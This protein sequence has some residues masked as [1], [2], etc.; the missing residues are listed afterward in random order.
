[1]SATW[2]SSELKLPFYRLDLADVI[3]SHLGESGSNLKAAFRQL[4]NGPGI[5]LLDEI[6]AIAK[7]RSDNSDIGEMKRLV[8]VLLQELD[9]RPMGSLVIAATNNAELIDPAAWRRFDMHIDFSKPDRR[10]IRKI[11]IKDFSKYTRRT[12]TYERWIDA[13]SILMENES[14][15]EIRRD[16]ESIQ[17]KSLLRQISLDESILDYAKTR[18]QHLSH[19][20]LI[21]LA[22]ALTTTKA[23]SQRTA[24]ELTGVARQTIRKRTNS[25][26]AEATA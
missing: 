7:T 14:F 22:V 24:C 18:T 8:T 9:Q 21:D 6:D 26:K 5:L 12:T 11:L 25:E 23:T 20:D 19:H 16:T 13:L 17:K 2:L 4:H 3:G 10:Q 1:M 15:S